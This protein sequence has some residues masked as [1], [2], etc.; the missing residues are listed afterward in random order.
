[1]KRRFMCLFLCVVTMLSLLT[2]HT[3]AAGKA[4]LDISLSSNAALSGETVTVT[5]TNGAMTLEALTGGIAFDKTKLECVSITGAN[6]A[7][8]DTIYLTKTTGL[9]PIQEVL[10]ASTVAEANQYGTVGFAW[11]N[12]ENQSYKAGTIATITFKVKDS[13]AGQTAITLY[14][15]SAGT[16]AY[17]NDNVNNGADVIVFSR[18]HS[19]D[20]STAWTQDKT[21]HWK[22]CSGCD[23][24]LDYAAHIP[25]PAATETEPQVCTVC[26]YVLAP[27]TGHIN[28][29]FGEDWMNNATH[30]W[31]SCS[32]CDEKADY[33]AHIP[34]PAA[35]ETEPQVCTVCQYVLA[36]A[37]GHIVHAPDGDWKYNETQHWQNCVGCTEV[38]G[39]ENHHGGYATCEDPA[40]CADCGQA[41]GELAAH[42]DLNGDNLCDVC[43][44]VLQ[45]PSPDD[46]EYDMW[47]GW[48]ISLYNR[49]FDITASAGEG[50]S[51]TPAGVSTVK[52]AK[53]QTYTI[54]AN[55][56]YEIVD[57]IV[58]GK[59]VGAVSEY[60]FKRVRAD[61][62][63]TATFARTE[64][65]NPYTDVS[66]KDWF[67]DAVR[68]V[69]DKGMMNG[70]GEGIF[71]PDVVS[72]RAM[73]VTVLW[74]MEGKPA[75]DQ[76]AA[77]T[78]VEDG[79]WYTDAV[80]WAYANE[81]VNGMDDETFAPMDAITH[82]QLAAIL[83]RYA[84]YKEYDTSAAKAIAGAQ[85]SDWAK[86]AVEWA[87]AAGLLDGVQKHDYAPQK[88]VCRAEMADVLM[89][90]CVAYAK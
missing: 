70:M 67:Y 26:Q 4:N 75:V 30:H 8:P 27:A 46:P 69:T 1:M 37:T 19:H 90:F 35:T 11:V 53:K 77:F 79:T 31:K 12:T 59:S 28:H 13:A 76:K 61:H 64:W 23:E 41:Y 7:Y 33:A 88:E 45:M 9:S 51:I 40:I 85:I 48:L 62:T 17:A 87:N 34:G 36:P 2:L 54:R 80:A 60:T 44:M 20:I 10:T 14:E 15:N 74:R 18:P 25:G 50:G 32:S 68:Y 22:S 84:A 21:H 38:M 73:I 42:V 78:D 29:V 66:D 39:L 83:Y 65:D 49:K 89:R 3:S 16:H 52:Y 72:S 55:Y 63:I 5:L 56:G 24:K 81:I 86:P 43:L 71:S 47:F 58:D 57:V 82:E 6:S